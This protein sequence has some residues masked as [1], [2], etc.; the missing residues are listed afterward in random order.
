MISVGGK[1]FCAQVVYKG[2]QGADSEL[3]WLGTEKGGCELDDRRISGTATV[4][5]VHLAVQYLRADYPTLE[6]IHLIDSST[7]KCRL[8]D[9]SLRPISLMKSYFLFYGS[10]FYESRFGAVPRYDANGIQEKFREGRS[11]PSTK[12]V[13][14]DF[15]NQDLNRILRPL[16][17]ESPTWGEFFR[18]IAEKYGDKKCAMIYP[19]YLHALAHICPEEMPVH[20]TID[21]TQFPRIEVTMVG[22][23]RRRTRKR[24]QK[25]HPL[26][27]GAW[28]RYDLYDM[29]YF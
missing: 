15:N 25:W 11:S 20:W 13:N 8:P 17:D 19:W 9:G 1:N 21:I 23:A 2:E 24:T 10:T 26:D 22:G 12:P 29:P 14:F 18:R 16:Y 7:Y 28:E 5:M 4:S 3:S 6:K 27:A